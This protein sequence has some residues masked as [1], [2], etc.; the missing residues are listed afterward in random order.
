MA[1]KLTKAQIAANK[2]AEAALAA[3]GNLPGAIPAN[4]NILLPSKEK[5]ETYFKQTKLDS[6]SIKAIVDKYA[7]K[8]LVDSVTKTMPTS[9]HGLVESIASLPGPLG[10]YMVQ[11][12][13]LENPVFGNDLYVRASKILPFLQAAG[14]VDSYNTSLVTQ[15]EAESNALSQAN[16]ALTSGDRSVNLS[17]KVGSIYTAA[18]TAENALVNWGI[19]TPELDALVINLAKSGMTNSG[20]IM[21]QV[22]ATKTY[23]QAYAGLAEYNAERAK[24]GD[25]LHQAMTEN[26][27]RS[28]AQSVQGAAQQYGNMV[29]NQQ[30]VGEL[31]KG[32]VTAPEFNQRMADIGSAVRNADPNVKALLKS[33]Y[34]ITEDHLFHYL[35]HGSLP[36][37]Q[38]E[39][40]NVDI[41][42]Y[43]SR[44]GLTGL[45]RGNFGQ[46]AD[47]AKL[48]GTAGNQGLGYGIGQIEQGVL[49]ASRDV[50][51]TKALPGAGTPT[52]DTKT[53]IA[54]QL[55]GFG[56]INQVAAQT[57]VARAEEAKVAPFEKGGGYAESAKGVIGLGAART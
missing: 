21:N 24:N 44:V 17:A 46:L 11:A 47:M 30:Q 53:L 54:S 3:L 31:L 8:P 41:Q 27:Y 40:A 13:G 9:S 37:L 56:G 49:G 5:L 16:A 45:S 28:Y 38:R 12:T 33:E 43:A 7:G 32:N 35:A 19:D 14:N 52:V 23:Q 26:E 6:K 25:P 51:L 34:G 20:E 18:A 22:R 48:A 36:N 55:A 1:S 39:V 4:T 57:Q 2:A 29:L 15:Y 42:D 10:A 50:T